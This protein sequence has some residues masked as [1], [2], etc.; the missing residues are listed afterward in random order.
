MKIK[1]DTMGVAHKLNKHTIEGLEVADLNSYDFI[2]LPKIYTKENMP[3]SQTHI[4]TTEDIPR[5]SHLNGVSLR[6]TDSEVG[7]LIANNVPGV[8]ETFI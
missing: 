2:E 1:L 4:P 5:W 3:V 7:I 6:Q 8:A